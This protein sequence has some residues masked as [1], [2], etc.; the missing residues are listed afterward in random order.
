[1]PHK[2]AW[3]CFSNIHTGKRNME[4]KV[5]KVIEIM[6]QNCAFKGRE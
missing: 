4:I 1:M 6:D 5:L 2:R 3:Y